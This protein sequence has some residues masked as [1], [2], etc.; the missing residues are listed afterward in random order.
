MSSQREWDVSGQTVSFRK[1]EVAKTEIPSMQL[2]H[3][4]LTYAKELERIV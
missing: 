4:T 2:I 3:E 1:A